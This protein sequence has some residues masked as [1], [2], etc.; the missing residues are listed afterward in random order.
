[1]AYFYRQK[2]IET[3]F[4]QYP[5]LFQIQRYYSIY[6]IKKCKKFEIW[7]SQKTYSQI[8]YLMVKCLGCGSNMS[9]KNNEM[10]CFVFLSHSL[11]GLIP[12]LIQTSLSIVSF[13]L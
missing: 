11:Y 8:Y 7:K 13:K 12:K 9:V 3:F 1:M 4:Y 5:L 6:N 10:Y 2:I